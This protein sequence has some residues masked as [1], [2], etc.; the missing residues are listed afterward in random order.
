MPSEIEIQRIQRETGMDRMQ[1]I[2]HLQARHFLL[3]R[4]NRFR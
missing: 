3:R 4:T 2:Y 1:A